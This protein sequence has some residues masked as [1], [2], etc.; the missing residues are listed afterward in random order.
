MQPGLLFAE[1]YPAS[2]S[3]AIRE[4]GGHRGEHGLPLLS[5]RAVDIQ[6][7]HCRLIP[8]TFDGRDTHS[9]RKAS[10][11]FG[12]FLPPIDDTRL[13]SPVEEEGRGREASE[14]QTQSV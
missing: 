10:V 4:P 9:T 12:L 5:N 8:D 3:P 13:L 2:A 11:P 14:L 7:F 6:S 1:S